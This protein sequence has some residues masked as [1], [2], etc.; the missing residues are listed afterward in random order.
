MT[1]TI[2]ITI[3]V[4]EFDGGGFVIA[5]EPDEGQTE[6]RPLKAV[7][8]LDE[9]CGAVQGILRN[10]NR[11]TLALKKAQADDIDGRNVI[12]PKRWWRNA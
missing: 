5:D 12:A 9:V 2:K 11:E 10:W 6:F 7:S 3:R 1:G 4:I 8:T